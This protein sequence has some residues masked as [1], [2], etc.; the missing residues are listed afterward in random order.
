[1]ETWTD[2]SAAQNNARERD[3]NE[4]CQRREAK[5]EPIRASALGIG[6]ASIIVDVGMEAV[7]DQQDDQDGATIEVASWPWIAYHRTVSEA[8]KAHFT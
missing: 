6:A 3:C 7:C 4:W 2:S 5:P 1:L 8:H